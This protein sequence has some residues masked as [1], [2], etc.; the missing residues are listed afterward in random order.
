MIKFNVLII[1]LRSYSGLQCSLC[2]VTK[3]VT[4][5]KKV[6][7]LTEIALEA[8]KINSAD[9]TGGNFQ[10]SWNFQL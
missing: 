7:F 5:D 8:L 4:K 10:L 1:I 2:V 6:C 9:E 3:A